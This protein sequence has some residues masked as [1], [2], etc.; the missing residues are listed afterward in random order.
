VQFSLSPELEQYGRLLREWSVEEVRPHARLA[1]ANHD[2]PSNWRDILATCPVYL[3][4]N[5]GADADPECPSFPEGESIRSLV[6]YEN[7]CYGDIW[8]QS[9]IG[10]G[11]GH[12]VVKLLGTKVQVDRWYDRFLRGD[13]FSSF[14]MTEPQAGSDASGITTRAVRDGDSW[15]LTGS[16]IFCSHAKRAEYVV[17]FAKLGDSQEN[18][19]TEAFIVERGTPGFELVRENENKLG[20]RSWQTSAVRLEDCVIPVENLLGASPDGSHPVRTGAGLAQ[21]L[22]VLNGNR[23]NAAAISTGLAQAVLDTAEAW[24]SENAS[25]FGVRHRDFLGLEVSK[26]HEALDR[27]R[28]MCRRAQWMRDQGMNNR[29]EASMAKAFAPETC[30]RVVRHC[31]RIIG[32][33]AASEDLL[34]EKWYRDLRIV[35]IFEGTGQIQRVIIGR[36]L[37][38]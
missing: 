27:G 19:A 8:L 22:S 35:D 37:T 11:I 6:Q 12:I 16:K 5:R 34:I 18:Q 2:A 29:A 28:R 17:V 1:D 10:R 21:A 13:G 20:L 38:R 33:E 24:L 9:L 32:P 14:A 23:P 3:S 4:Q 7:V 15:V 31:M 36:E 26:M 30:E 25:N